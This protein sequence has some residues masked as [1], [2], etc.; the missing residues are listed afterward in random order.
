MVLLRLE[1]QH[2]GV[3]AG[4]LLLWRLLRLGGRLGGRGGREVALRF[5]AGLALEDASGSGSGAAAASGAASGASMIASSK[6]PRPSSSAAAGA[7]ACCGVSGSK[8]SSKS[9]P[10]EAGVAGVLRG[11][12]RRRCG[13]PLTLVACVCSR[14]RVREMLRT[15]RPSVW[16]ASRRCWVCLAV[17]GLPFTH[18]L[19][20]WCS[21]GAPCQTDANF[22]PRSPKR[23]EARDMAPGATHGEPTKPVCATSI[24]RGTRAEDA[25]GLV[26]AL[27]DEHESSR[28]RAETL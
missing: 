25:S 6:S 15:R 21:A 10:Y 20:L 23:H 9:S 26:C 4:R 8:S 27:R 13:C 11:R 19:A 5:V 7:G 12:H 24:R 16:A 22:A 17:R 3:G 14:R 2:V 28:A 1:N 18:D